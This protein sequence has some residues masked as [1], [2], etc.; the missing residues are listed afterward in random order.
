M[1]ILG[2]PAE[3]LFPLN[4]TQKLAAVLGRVRSYICRFQLIYASAYLLYGRH[5]REGHE[6]FGPVYNWEQN[7]VRVRPPTIT[8]LQ[9]REATSS[10]GEDNCAIALPRPPAPS[11]NIH[12]GWLEERYPEELMKIAISDAQLTFW[13]FSSHSRSQAGEEHTHEKL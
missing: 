6:I 1:L 10:P 11:G 2:S 12:L 4:W 13:T 5:G 3:L 9:G 8:E 7:T